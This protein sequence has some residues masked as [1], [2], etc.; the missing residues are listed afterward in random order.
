MPSQEIVRTAVI[1][2]SVLAYIAAAILTA[3]QIRILEKC[4]PITSVVVTGTGVL[5][6]GILAYLIAC[7]MPYE[8]QMRIMAAL[9][10]D[11]K[12]RGIL[13]LFNLYRRVVLHY[14][15]QQIQ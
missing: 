6:S 2:L 13:A 7:V 5:I 14:N 3:R 4:S 8:L 15:S 10:K 11:H 9:S 1:M 12:K